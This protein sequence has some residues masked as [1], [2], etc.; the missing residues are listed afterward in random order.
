MPEP[1]PTYL[2]LDSSNSSTGIPSNPSP[3]FLPLRFFF[4]LYNASIFGVRCRW[5]GCRDFLAPRLHH[6]VE[7]VTFGGLFSG[8]VLGFAEVVGEVVEFEGMIFEEFDEL[9]VT[10]TDGAGGGGAA[11]PW[12]SV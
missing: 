5:Y 4:F 11:A 3:Y 8:E 10:G 2:S 1:Y 9:P 7:L 12:R 6:L